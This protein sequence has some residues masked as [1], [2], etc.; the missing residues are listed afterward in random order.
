MYGDQYDLYVDIGAQ[1]VQRERL[2]FELRLR[3]DQKSLFCGRH[4]PENVFKLF[5]WGYV[6]LS[7]CY[8]SL[9]HFFKSAELKH[10]NEIL[11]K[12]W[13]LTY[14]TDIDDF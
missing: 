1:R 6:M 3:F 5:L 10:A 8:S 12:G 14:K 4:Q 13:N 11:S 7:F 2:I 9:Y